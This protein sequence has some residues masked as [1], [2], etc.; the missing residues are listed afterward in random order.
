[1][2]W[3]ILLNL[4]HKFLLNLHS[5]IPFAMICGILFDMIC[6]ILLDFGI[7]LNLHCG[8]PLTFRITHKILFPRICSDD[9][10]QILGAKNDVDVESLTMELLWSDLE[11]KKM[12]QEHHWFAGTI[13]YIRADAR[14]QEIS[15][16]ID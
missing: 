3:G 16:A 14:L 4:V 8:I 13:Y 15:M 10:S 11:G 9:V 2:V 7:L 6:G 1:M 5:G 12:V